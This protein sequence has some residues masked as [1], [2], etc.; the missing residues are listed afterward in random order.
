LLSVGGSK[1]AAQFILRI[2]NGVFLFVLRPV[3]VK[4]DPL[5]AVFLEERNDIFEPVVNG[6][7]TQQFTVF[8]A[9]IAKERYEVEQ[10]APLQ[11]FKIC[12]GA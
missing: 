3:L 12:L 7:I 11:L 6:A 9:A 1:Q 10:I 8:L 2:R 4:H 5:D